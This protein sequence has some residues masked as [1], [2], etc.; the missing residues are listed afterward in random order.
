VTFAVQGTEPATE[1]QLGKCDSQEA[2]SNDKTVRQSKEPFRRSVRTVGQK[3][4]VS[5][6]RAHVGIPEIL[7]STES[8][9]IPVK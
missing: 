8:S 1:G 4:S 5:W 2:T 9:Y 3:P 7:P 6:G